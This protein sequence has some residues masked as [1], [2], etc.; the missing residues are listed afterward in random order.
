[1]TRF[2]ILGLAVLVRQPTQHKTTA[3]RIKC[4]DAAQTSA[5]VSAFSLSRWLGYFAL[6]LIGSSFF[7]FLATKRDGGGKVTALS[8]SERVQT[9]DA[10]LNGASTACK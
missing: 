2:A 4:R 10:P 5:V 7:A 8:P 6:P 1:L 9:I 3:Q